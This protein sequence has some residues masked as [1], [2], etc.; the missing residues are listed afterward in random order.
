MSVTL[1]QSYL[2]SISNFIRL[3]LP[4]AQSKCGDLVPSV[5]RESLPVKIAA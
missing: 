1:T 3:G 2:H 5:E 4:R